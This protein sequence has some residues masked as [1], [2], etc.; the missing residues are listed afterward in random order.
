[1]YESYLII[2]QEQSVEGFHSRLGALKNQEKNRKAQITRLKDEVARAELKL[3]TAPPEVDL[4]AL[5]EEKVSCETIT[6][7]LLL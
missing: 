7:D 3:E 6:L 2:F 4:E 5:K 1:V